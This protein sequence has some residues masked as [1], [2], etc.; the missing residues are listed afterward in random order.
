[1][2]PAV[3]SRKLS[4]PENKVEL[5]NCQRE[6]RDY[7][8]DQDINVYTS[9]DKLL[10][11]HSLTRDNVKLR[12]EG[13]VF[14]P[15]QSIEDKLRPSVSLIKINKPIGVI[16]PVGSEITRDNFCDEEKGSTLFCMVFPI[17]KE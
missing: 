13:Y 5:T 7:L 6:F 15:K 12:N 4:E 2:N 16:Y 10:E 9:L 14:K 3:I 1:M 11:D 8:I 17:P